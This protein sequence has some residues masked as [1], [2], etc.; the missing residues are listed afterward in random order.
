LQ[1]AEQI[2]ITGNLTIKVPNREALLSIKAAKKEYDDLLKLAGDLMVSIEKHYQTRTSPE[3]LDE[4][5][6]IGI[7]VEIREELYG[8]ENRVKSIE[9]RT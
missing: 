3:R 4:Q 1:S 2:L 9:L 5:K 7:L 6:A 8:G